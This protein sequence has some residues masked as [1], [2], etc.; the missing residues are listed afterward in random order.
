M[1][2]ATMTGVIPVYQLN[3]TSQLNYSNFLKKNLSCLRLVVYRRDVS[4][5]GN[6][7]LSCFNAG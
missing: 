4:M 3:V 7:F 5:D 6:E 1:D 2:E